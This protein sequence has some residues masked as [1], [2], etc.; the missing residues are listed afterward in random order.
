MFGLYSN[1]SEFPGLVN[2]QS[3]VTVCFGAKSKKLPSYYAGENK[4][5]NSESCEN[6]RSVGVKD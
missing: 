2:M 1:H 5:R 3:T 4:Q 6:Y